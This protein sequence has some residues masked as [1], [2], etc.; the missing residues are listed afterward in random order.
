MGHTI[1]GLLRHILIAIHPNPPLTIK[2]PI[3]RICSAFEASELKP[4]GSAAWG[5]WVYGFKG[6]RFRFGFCWFPGMG[7]PA[8]RAAAWTSYA[9]VTM[10][11][12]VLAH[13]TFGHIASVLKQALA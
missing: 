2:A 10:L 6:S 1:L 9:A 7:V 11:S 5:L 4:Q 13:M 8:V 3:L 12:S